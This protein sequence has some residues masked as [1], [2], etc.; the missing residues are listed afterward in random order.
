MTLTLVSLMAPNADAYYRALAAYLS[1]RTGLGIAA[2]DQ[3]DW[4]ERERM[5]DRGEAQIGFI[6]GLPYALRADC[7]VR[8]LTLLA[9]PVMRARRYAGRA[10]YFS[11]VIVRRESSFRSFAD[12]RGAIWSY[13]EPGSQSGYNITRYHLARLGHREGYFG[14]VVEAGTHQRSIRMVA[15]GAVDASAVDSTVLELELARQPELASRLRVVE[16]LGP[17]TIPPAVIAADVPEAVREAIRS[18][19][20]RMHSEEAGRR[21]LGEFMLAR[22]VPVRDADYDDIRRM[23][24]EAE[25]VS[26]AL[27]AAPSLPGAVTACV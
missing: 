23:A 10:R 25:S 1:R 5:L 3:V 11:D 14:R 21:L 9:A 19:L 22:Y 12:L 7:P 6:C 2:V 8:D 27:P 13:N 16:T 4:R 20:L 15:E 26:L 18:A 17:S 24:R